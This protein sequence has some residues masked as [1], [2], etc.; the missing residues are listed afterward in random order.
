MSA[1][2]PVYNHILVLEDTHLVRITTGSF[3]YMERP[4]I[5][6]YIV[7]DDR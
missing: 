1:E 7:I 3:I 2:E 4:H 5:C 6:Y